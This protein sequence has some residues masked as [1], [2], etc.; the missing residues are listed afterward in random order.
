MI[1]ILKPSFLTLFINSEMMK[2][3]SVSSLLPIL[4]TF[5]YSIKSVLSFPAT[6]FSLFVSLA[7]IA[8]F[9]LY[10]S[11]SFFAFVSLRFSPSSPTPIFSLKSL[12]FLLQNS[13]RRDHGF[14]FFGDIVS[15]FSQ[16]RILCCSVFCSHLAIVGAATLR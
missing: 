12:L 10:L 16:Y 7:L 15:S 3:P 6:C 5:C 13:F 11:S 4:F 8:S 14:N 9:L 2:M 1:H